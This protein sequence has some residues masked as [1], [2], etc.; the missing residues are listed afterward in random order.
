MQIRVS[1]KAS[2]EPKITVN[3]IV[4]NS[5]GTE[6]LIAER[7]STFYTSIYRVLLVYVKKQFGF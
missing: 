5:S 4:I 6:Y 2:Y 3:I 1:Y 7:F